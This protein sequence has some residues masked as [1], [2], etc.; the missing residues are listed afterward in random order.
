[1][2]VF[3]SQFVFYRVFFVALKLVALA[4]SSNEIAISN[5]TIHCPPP[6]LVGTFYFVYKL[7]I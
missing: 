3:F 7:L 6:K 5:L 4:Q 1:M 2:A